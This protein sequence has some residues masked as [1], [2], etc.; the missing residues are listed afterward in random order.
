MKTFWIGLCFCVFNLCAIAQSNIKGI[1]QNATT[2]QAIANAHI[3]LLHSKPPKGT[4]SN[5]QGKFQLKIINPL[6]VYLQ[7]SA[8]GFKTDTILYSIKQN[9]KYLNIALQEQSTSIQKVLIKASKKR[10]TTQAMERLSL[11][12]IDQNTL[13]QTAGGATDPQRALL[14][15]AGIK[16]QGNINNGISI[17]GNK[18]TAM[19]WYLEGVAIDDPNH[20]S[21]GNSF[22]GSR[23]INGAVS[24]ING[25]FLQKIDLHTSAF[26]AEYGNAIS[27]AL[28][29]HLRQ[30]NDSTFAY[31][32]KAGVLGLEASVDAPMQMGGSFW[33]SY[34]YSTLGLLS[35]MKF[36]LNGSLAEYQDI[37]F[38]VQFPTKKWGAISVFGLTGWSNNQNDPNSSTFQTIQDEWLLKYHSLAL[39]IKHQKE[40]K[41]AYWTSTLAFTKAINQHYYYSS[42]FDFLQHRE[43]TNRY[44]YLKIKNTLRLSSSYTHFIGKD[45]QWKSGVNIHLPH[46]YWQRKAQW[47]RIISK[48]KNITYYTEA[49][50]QWQQNINPFWKINI[51]LHFL[52]FGYNNQISVAPRFSV[53]YKANPQHQIQLSAGLHSQ[54]A[55]LPLYMY[56]EN[57][58]QVNKNLKL[59]KSFHLVLDYRY[60]FLPQWSIAL[61][62]YVQYH[63][64]VPQINLSKYLFDYTG[65]PIG[66]FQDSYSLINYDIEQ[67]QLS[68]DNK[69]KGLNYGV[70]FTLKK[71]FSRKYFVLLSSAYYRS[72]YKNETM[73]TWRISQYDGLFTFALSGGKDFVWGK[74]Q[75]HKIGLSARIISSGGYLKADLYQQQNKIERQKPYFKIDTRLAY[76]F[77]RPKFSFSAIADLLNTTNHKNETADYFTQGAG[78]LPVLTFQVCFKK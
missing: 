36:D 54:I 51:G 55:S 43:I 66:F 73:K 44:T 22:G 23:Y 32:L 24:A 61:S 18:P 49:Y 75:Q 13:Q 10:A 47:Q 25:D 30:G 76:T 38:K 14:S 27:G 33:F 52:H 21:I 72:F 71:D 68:L 62:P 4:I 63:F 67:T 42:Y 1:V 48:I 8:L 28:H 9:E 39:G 56:A 45:K 7:V 60:Q 35:K 57:G 11:K 29:L 50:T 31:Q 34:R 17:K 77:S 58:L 5:A 74:N 78:I 64:D 37:N 6:P 59:A 69:G 26:P 16:N 2:Q 12:T 3:V 46:I 15:Y 70:E 41:N 19:Q 65:L 20:F 53:K 40:F